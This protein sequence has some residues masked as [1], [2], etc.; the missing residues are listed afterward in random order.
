[1]LHICPGS[2]PTLGL[3]IDRCIN[4]ELKCLNKWL[5]V[6]KL[7]ALNVSKTEFMLVTTRQK[8]ALYD[9]LSIN[10]NGKP[11]RQVKTATTTLG[12][13]IEETL[14]SSKQVEFIYKKS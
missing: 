10:I 4:K 14:S 1:M 2:P 5:V 13:H 3:N 7:S 11:I 12:L 6:N 8:H 9:A